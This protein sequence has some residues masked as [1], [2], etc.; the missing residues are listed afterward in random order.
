MLFRSTAFSTV[1]EAVDSANDAILI[2]SNGIDSCEIW[3]AQGTYVIPATI[4]IYSNISVIGGF[5]GEWE[6][7]ENDPSKT[8]FD[9]SANKMDNIIDASGASNV[10]LRS[11]TLYGNT[12]DGAGDN[13]AGALYISNA[14]GFVVN[15]VVFDTNRAVGASADNGYEGRGGA[16]AVIESD[17]VFSDCEFKDRKS[18]V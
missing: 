16:V 15:Y 4:K 13:Y 5:M 11:L 14:T 10:T 8:V 18:V 2:E 7:R 6:K 9:G 17:A 12:N 3:V 1:Q